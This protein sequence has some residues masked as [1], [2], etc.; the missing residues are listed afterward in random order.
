MVERGTRRALASAIERVFRQ[1]ATRLAVAEC[2]R[3]Y[4]QRTD[5]VAIG[6]P[7]SRVVPIAL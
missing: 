6:M 2:G 1:A 4:Q 5:T 3:V 7:W